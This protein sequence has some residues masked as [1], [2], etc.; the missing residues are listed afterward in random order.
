VTN[1]WLIGVYDGHTNQQFWFEHDTNGWITLVADAATSGRRVQYEY[2]GAGRLTNVIN[3]LGQTKGYVYDDKGR[4]VQVNQ[5]M[6]RV[7]HLDYDARGFVTNVWRGDGFSRRYEYQYDSYRK[8]YYALVTS[9]GGQ[10]MERRYNEYGERIWGAM[11][12]YVQFDATKPEPTDPN[13]YERDAKDNVTKITYPDGRF[14]TMEYN[15]PNGEMTRHV[16]EAGVA[17]TYEFDAQGNL[18]RQIEAAGTAVARETQYEYDTLNRQTVTRIKNPNGPDS[19]NSRTYD[20]CGRIAT[21]TDPLGNV[22]SNVYDRYGNL[23]LATVNGQQAAAFVFDDLNRLVSATDSVGNT[24]STTY[25]PLGKIILRTVTASSGFSLQS[26]AYSYDSEG[27]PMATTNELGLTTHTSYDAD[28]HLLEQTDTAGHT[29]RFVY[30]LKNQVISEFRPEG[31][32]YFEY[33]DQNRLIRQMDPQGGETRWDYDAAG[34]LARLCMPGLT[35]TYEYDVRGRVTV[36]RT[37]TAAST[38]ETR[39]ALDALGRVIATTD[40]LG[41][42]T[43]MEFDALGRRSAVVNAINATNRFEYDV[44][45]NLTKFTDSKGNQTTFEYDLGNKLTKKTYADNNHVDFTYDAQGRVVEKVDA[46]GQKTTF[47]YDSQGWLMTHAFYNAGNSLVKTVSYNYDIKGRMIS[48]NDGTYSG[49]FT[50]DEINKIQS[51]TVNYGAFSK[52][53]SC[54][55]DGLYRTTSFTGPDGKEIGYRYSTDGNLTGIQIPEEG[56]I[57]YSYNG[58][59]TL[60]SQTLPGGNIRYFGYDATMS[61]GTNMALDAAQNVLMNRGYSR[62][63]MGT[64]IGQQTESGTIAYQYDPID[65]LTG[66]TNVALGNEWFAYDPMGNRVSSS[67]TILNVTN[68]AA[69]SANALNQ[70]PQISNNECQISLTYD[71]NGNLINQ[72]TATATNQYVWDVENR[73]IGFQ[74]RKGTN[75]TSAQYFYDPFGRRLSKIV[76]GNTNFFFYSDEGLIGEYDSLGNEIR[77]YGY[78]PN[79][80]WMSEPVWMRTG[81]ASLNEGETNY[82]YYLNDHLGAPQR[83]VRKNGAT[84]WAAV[85]EAFGAAYVMPGAIVTNNLRFSSQYFDE[86]SGLHNNTQRYLDPISGRYL[87]RDPMEEEGGA[88]LYGFV[89]NAPIT[90]VDV[91]GE[92]N[93]DVHND[94]TREWAK[95]VGAKN[96]AATLLGIWD[97]DVDT[98]Y[99]PTWNK[100]WHFGATRKKLTAEYVQKAKDNCDAAK[101]ADYP[102]LASKD[103][104][105]ALHPL[106]DWWAHGDYPGAPMVHNIR[107]KITPDV[108]PTISPWQYP[109]RIDLDAK[110]LDGRPTGDY[111]RRRN[112]TIYIKG[113]NRIKGT[114]RDTETAIKGYLEW[115]RINGSCKCKSFFLK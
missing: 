36:Q 66:V 44:F 65:Q 90:T 91:L 100:S 84:A 59:G 96:E 3:A 56:T 70:Y 83:L 73:L 10:V 79:C 43:G 104:G 15:G 53:Y 89:N 102:Y 57:G 40:P 105:Y 114:Q 25:N 71:L 106:Q 115:L 88:N 37:V 51:V 112:K 80:D 23:V 109:D 38:L 35:N 47:A 63:V 78:T 52:T 41:R 54:V 6:D 31:W 74:K 7:T 20:E 61:L 110:T 5:A 86:E 111:V 27:R 9:S 75:L 1:G 93:S 48:W 55:Y 33:D 76:N 24:T 12:G 4:I 101:K 58:N 64:I 98:A 62:N 30:N 95:K 11:N 60:Y 92:W 34:L 50:Y 8:E 69:Y 46:K 107:G 45:G 32:F 103:L 26:T 2:D 16:D 17:T 19:V 87:S 14:V 82:L 29:N 39:F 113:E 72:T 108:P 77:S 99:N 42:T 67:N 28:G 18:T 13:V 49:S 68:V 97:N 94:M 22:S 21:V 85:M 81:I